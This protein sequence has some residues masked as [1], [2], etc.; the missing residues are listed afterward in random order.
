ML[1]RSINDHILVYATEKDELAIQV[2]NNNH[3][4]I[5]I[6]EE[7]HYANRIYNSIEEMK[8]VIIDNNIPIKD[9]NYFAK[10]AEIELKEGKANENNK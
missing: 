10:K 2:V 7:C 4:Y 9:N 1:F 5:E 6:E 3:I 8:K